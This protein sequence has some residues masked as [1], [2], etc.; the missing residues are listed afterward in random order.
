MKTIHAICSS[1]A[2]VLICSYTVCFGASENSQ[3][4]A[5]GII[6]DILRSDDQQMQTVAISMIR[7]MEGTEVTKALAEELPNLSATSQVQ[8]ISALG[9]R[10]DSAA[11]PAVIN[12]TKSSEESVRI[13][14]LKALGQLVIA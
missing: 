5:V 13:A 3:N 7:D 12:A 1:L 8:L 10:G 2:L 11:L 6:L 9:D 14:A 4:D